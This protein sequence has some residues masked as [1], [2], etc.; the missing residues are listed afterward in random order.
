MSDT[1][2]PANVT[3]RGLDR[4]KRQLLLH[5]ALFDDPSAYAAGV[6]DTIDA[7]RVAARAPARPV[8]RTRI[9]RIPPSSD[10][11]QARSGGRARSPGGGAGA[12][13]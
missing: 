13:E 11:E 8:E 12:P 2:T 4:L 5:A 9:V 1:E 10:A 7:L 6:S 3:G